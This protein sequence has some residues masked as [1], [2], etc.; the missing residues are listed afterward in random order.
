MPTSRRG[1]H[2][3]LKLLVACVVIYLIFHV[4]VLG[5][6]GFSKNKVSD[7]RPPVSKAS[8]VKWTG[9]ELR[10]VG[11]KAEGGAVPLVTRRLDTSPEKSEVETREDSESKQLK[12]KTTEVGAQLVK[13]PERGGDVSITLNTAI[14]SVKSKK[15]LQS[16]IAEIQGLIDQGLVV[17]RWSG[18]KEEPGVP[19]GPGE[20][21]FEAAVKEFHELSLPPM[22]RMLNLTVCNSCLSK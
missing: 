11:E 16:A 12:T 22:L 1:R 18:E 15:S 2:L 3:I 20:I 10:G 7:E 17:P 13:G 14:D 8:D 6:V 19:G 5:K 9:D 21:I 4:S